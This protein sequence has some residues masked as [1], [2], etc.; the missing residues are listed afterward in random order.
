M[1]RFFLISILFT[2]AFAVPGRSQEVIYTF[3]NNYFRSSPYKTSFSQFLQHLMKDPSLSDRHTVLRSDS[4]LFSFSGSY[5]SFNPFFFK[6]GRVEVSLFDAPLQ[7]ADSLPPADTIMGYQL[8]AYADDTD[9]GL[10]EIKKEQQKIHR[11]YGKKFSNYN[12][13][14]YKD[15][16]NQEGEQ[17]NYFVAYRMLSPLSV[18]WHRL[19][20]D[21]KLVLVISMRLNIKQNVA[22]L[23]ELPDN[24]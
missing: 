22:Q 16:S 6:P 5:T 4:T 21:K 2:V 8:L 3:A 1:Q 17:Y 9:R 24:P 10:K 18:S 20:E 12:Y 14:E 11:H 7:L 19:K 23:P 13:E 15:G